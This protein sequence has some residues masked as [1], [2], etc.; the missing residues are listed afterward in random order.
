LDKIVRDLF[1]YLRTF[2]YFSSNDFRFSNE[3]NRYRLS[4]RGKKWDND[5][6][7][8]FFCELLTYK[9]KEIVNKQA[10]L[11]KRIYEID[12]L[13]QNELI[14]IKNKPKVNSLLNGIENELI[15]RIKRWEGLLPQDKIE[16]WLLNFDTKEDK[17]TALRLLDKLTYIT[18]KN[19]AQLINSS[20]NLL[21]SKINMDTP[22]KYFFSC[23]GDIT[24]G[25]TH[26]AKHFQEESRIKEKLFKNTE[27][28]QLF[29]KQNEK[30]DT[31]ILIDDF[32]GSG[33]TYLK[34]YKKNTQM[35]NNCSEVFFIALI[36]LI[37]GINKIEQETNTKVLCKYILDKGDQ[38]IDGT[39]FDFE[40]KREIRRLI[41]KYSYPIKPDYVNGYDNCQLLLAFEDN[42]PNNSIGIL[43]W[44]ENWTALF[45]RK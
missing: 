4:L 40:E 44:S 10:H 16:N 17:K 25:S 8:N 6:I 11:E 5:S 38:V 39:L 21:N 26:L 29:I 42:I 7:S 41:D 28:L 18:N 24:S 34:W 27:E 15:P 32:V 9:K 37:K 31:L 13:I 35:L 43:W 3:V 23:I 14:L 45:D 22:Q 20:N 30:I 12:E 33:D 36:A 19:L 2:E 1:P